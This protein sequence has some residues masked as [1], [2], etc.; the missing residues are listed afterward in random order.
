MGQA[1]QTLSELIKVYEKNSLIAKV[2]DK[3]LQLTQEHITPNLE[4]LI[5]IAYEFRDTLDQVIAN[6]KFDHPWYLKFKKHPH[7]LTQYPKGT[8]FL[9]TKIFYKY[10]KNDF[11]VSLQNF[12]NQ[13]GV[14][15]MVWGV[16]KEQ[17]F[18]TQLQIGSLFFDVANDAVD[19]NKERVNIEYYNHTTFRNVTDLKDFVTIKEVYHKCKISRNPVP[20]LNEFFP[21]IQYNKGLKILSG[22]EE[23]YLT[24]QEFDL[25][26]IKDSLSEKDRNHLLEFFSKIPL[27]KFK[28]E[29]REIVYQKLKKMVNYYNHLK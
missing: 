5:T 26:Q 22:F 8:C 13:G 23:I 10:L 12:I 9:T 27:D 24:Q 21:L 1:E 16:I 14:F 2:D 18:Q 6:E 4:N 25:H 17:Y 15:K 19:V 29:P 28:K 20:V 3:Q 7:F 11:P